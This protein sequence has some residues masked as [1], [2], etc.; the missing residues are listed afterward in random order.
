LFS[1]ALTNVNKE[2]LDSYISE[3]NSNDKEHFFGLVHTRRVKV[4]HEN[5]VGIDVPRRIVK[6]KRDG[7]IHN[8]K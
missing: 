4:S 2:I 5:I 1:R 8:F 7:N 6:I 3:L